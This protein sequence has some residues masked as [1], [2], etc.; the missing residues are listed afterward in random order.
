[1]ARVTLTEPHGKSC[2]TSDCARPASVHFECGDI[3]SDY[4][5]ACID[6]I[7]RRIEATAPKCKRCRLPLV[8]GISLFRFFG[9][10]TPKDQQ[11]YWH[12]RCHQDAFSHR[13]TR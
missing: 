9:D 13:P 4:C 3:G 5:E 7:R 1:M 2:A 6:Q 11:G 8:D 12:D 10:P